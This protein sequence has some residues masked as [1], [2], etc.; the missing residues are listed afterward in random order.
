MIVNNHE[1]SQSS[2]VSCQISAAGTSTAYEGTAVVTR[3][4]PSVCWDPN[5]V[6]WNKNTV[7]FTRYVVTILDKSVNKGSVYDTPSF[8]KLL[9]C[10]SR[11]W[12]R[13]HPKHG[14]V[15]RQVELTTEPMTA[16]LTMKSTRLKMAMR[17]FKGLRNDENMLIIGMSV[18][19]RRKWQAEIQKTN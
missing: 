3:P 16:A 8:E 11:Q 9:P 15:I 17:Y 5:P 4:H 6:I 13:S 2:Q 14:L 19:T 12:Y 10:A 7:R 1:N 18:G